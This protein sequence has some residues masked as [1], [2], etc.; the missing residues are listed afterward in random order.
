M[1]MYMCFNFVHARAPI[2]FAE[3][4]S[5]NEAKSTKSSKKAKP[6]QGKVKSCK[7]ITVQCMS[8]WLAH[9]P[10]PLLSLAYHYDH[11]HP[12]GTQQLAYKI[13]GC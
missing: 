8:V 10:S 1:Y 4:K 11:P 3:Q 13:F 9:L 2:Y 7:Y 6:K 5:P 12:S